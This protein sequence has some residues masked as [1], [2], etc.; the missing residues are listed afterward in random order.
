MLTRHLEKQLTESRTEVE[1]LRRRVELLSDESQR[2]ARDK[3]AVINTLSRKVWHNQWS[4]VGTVIV[5][6]IAMLVTVR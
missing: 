6:F 4:S 3:A 5:Y 2:V 1:T